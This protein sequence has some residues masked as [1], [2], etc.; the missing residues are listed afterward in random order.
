M[1]DA[2][3]ILD[4]LL[5]TAP[6]STLEDKSRVGVIPSGSWLST[7]YRARRSLWPDILDSGAF[8]ISKVR[9]VLIWLQSLSSEI[10]LWT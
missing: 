2:P 8:W 4:L 5:C 6:L 10:P 9:L 3:R 7:T 1:Q